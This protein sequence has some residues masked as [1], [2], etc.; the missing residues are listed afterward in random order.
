MLGKP[1]PDKCVRP[2]RVLTRFGI[3]L[4]SLDAVDD[5]M[6]H[7]S[8]SES[9]RRVT[10]GLPDLERLVS[11]I[12]ANACK[13]SDFIKVLDAF[14]KMASGFNDMTEKAASFSSSSV[15]TLINQAP[16]L[17]PIL[18]E[19]KSMF[20]LD[21][22]RIIPAEGASEV[23]DEATRAVQAIEGQLDSLLARY[24]KQI[25]CKEMT[26][27][28]SNLGSKEV[29]HIQ[30]PI[31]VKVPDTWTKLGGTKS[32]ARYTTRETQPLIR[33]VQEARETKKVAFGEFYG[34]MM[35]AFDQQREMW[36]KAVR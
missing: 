9:F 10:K 13:Q 33:E 20:F 18:Q 26:F 1:F 12:H 36:L 21:E 4:A 19:V 31:K 5:L 11:R 2:G 6:E 34:E 27:W 32:L 23:C 7:P 30:V 15:S 22:G 25:G 17:A 29:Y 35:R 14:S 28:H 8:F 3:S 24:K 16:D